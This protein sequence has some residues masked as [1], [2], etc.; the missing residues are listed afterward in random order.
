MSFSVIC[1]ENKLARILDMFLSSWNRTSCQHKATQFLCEVHLQCL[2]SHWYALK[3]NTKNCNMSQ[4]QPHLFL[5]GWI[6]IR[7]NIQY[8]LLGKMQ[9]SFCY[10]VNADMLGQNTSIFRLLANFKWLTN[11]ICT[12]TLVILQWF[13]WHFKLGKLQI[14]KIIHQ[15]VCSVEDLSI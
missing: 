14:F 13:P 7:I 5:P 9:L 10:K 6:C 2:Q 3:W 11:N 4:I 8:I 15:Y 1:K 12:D